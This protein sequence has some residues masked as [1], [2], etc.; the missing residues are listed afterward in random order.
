MTTFK[1]PKLPASHFFED[2][3]SEL[4]K[5]ELARRVEYTKGRERDRDPTDTKA[6]WISEH[7][8]A[9]AERGVVWPFSITDKFVKNAWFHTL[10]QREQE[11][12]LLYDDFFEFLKLQFLG[13]RDWGLGFAGGSTVHCW[14]SLCVKKGYWPQSLAAFLCPGCCPL[15]C[16]PL[17]ALCPSKQDI[18]HNWWPN[19]LSFSWGVSGCL[20]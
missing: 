5:A 13:Q 14:D 4:V 3:N 9:A 6:K 19:P 20:Y 10:T 2:N 8:E 1:L 7:K 18:G 17:Q 11:L 16:P 12:L 15:P